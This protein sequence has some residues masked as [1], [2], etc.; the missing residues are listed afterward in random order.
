MK[1]IKTKEFETI[2]TAMIKAAGK[3]VNELARNE[4]SQCV[5]SGKILKIIEPAMCA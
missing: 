2:N 3:I 4:K 5:R 1:K